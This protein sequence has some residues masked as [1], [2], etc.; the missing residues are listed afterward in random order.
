MEKPIFKNFIFQNFDK[1]YIFTLFS[2]FS[3]VKKKFLFY[4]SN[5][6]EILKSKK[7]TSSTTQ[8]IPDIRTYITTLKGVLKTAL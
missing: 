6:T 3:T 4:F 8:W 1:K 7:A 5:F 2:N